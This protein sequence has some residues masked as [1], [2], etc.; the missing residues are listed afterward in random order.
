MR[1]RRAVHPIVLI[2]V[3]SGLAGA[4]IA[5]GCSAT[6]EPTTPSTGAGGAGGA[7]GGMPAS[8]S[9][10]GQG[11]VGGVD[12]VAGEEAPPDVRMDPCGS[13]CGPM[14]LCDPGHVGLDDDCDGQVDESCPCSTGQAHF[15]FKGDPSF[16]KAPGCYD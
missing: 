11:G 8:S 14:E 2:L 1:T 9:S 3:V 10:T 5:S 4:G 7:G 15:C 12:I 16:H 6:N 13:G